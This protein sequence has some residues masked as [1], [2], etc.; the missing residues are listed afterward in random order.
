ME[1][2]N[3]CAALSYTHDTHDVKNVC[4]IKTTKDL[5]TILLTRKS[6][7]PGRWK[8]LESTSFDQTFLMGYLS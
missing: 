4:Y 2:F 3:F 7:P 6:T 1:N 8:P 5:E